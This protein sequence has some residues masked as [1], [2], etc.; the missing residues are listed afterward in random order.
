LYARREY[1]EVDDNVVFSQDIKDLVIKSDE[2]IVIGCNTHFLT[3]LL[4]YLNS[5]N[6]KFETRIFP[7]E[8]CK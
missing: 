8:K 2:V 4:D 6:K 5:F 1:V 3:Q 7:E